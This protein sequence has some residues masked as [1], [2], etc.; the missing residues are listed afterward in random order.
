MLQ[1]DFTFTKKIK[2][3]WKSEGNHIALSRESCTNKRTYREY[4]VLSNTP[5]SKLVNLLVLRATD[6]LELIPIGR[7]VEVKMNV[8]GK[9]NNNIDIYSFDVSYLY[10]LMKVL[11]KIY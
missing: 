4:K 2:D 3:I 1:V 7:Y 8:M 11:S 5:L 6:F 9:Y 10:I